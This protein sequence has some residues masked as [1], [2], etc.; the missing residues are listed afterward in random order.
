MSDLPQPRISGVDGV[1]RVIQ[2]SGE[3]VALVVDSPHSGR[4]YPADFQHSVGMFALRSAEDAYVDELCADVSASGASVLLADF[5]RSYIDVNRNEDDITSSLIDGRWPTLL[6]PSEKTAMGIGLVR[7][8]LASGDNIYNRK[9][10]VAE[11]KAR[12]ER[13]YRPYHHTLAALLDDSVTRFG[14]VWHIDMHSMASTANAVTPEVSGKF[15]EFDIVLGDLD[16]SSC[17]PALTEFVREYFSACG[18]RVRI[19]D[20]YK[21]AAMTQRYGQPSQRRHTLQIEFNRALYLDE[22][23][24]RTHRGFDK[25]RSNIGELFHNLRQFVRSRAIAH[26]Q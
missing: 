21:G 25:L 26:D 12:I 8:K 14:A 24:V 11:V 5:P 13:Y 15:R 3:P 19:N 16:G 9:L 18:Y 23:E 17:E 22:R 6:A 4:I 1:L 10:P 2:P 20:P 7:A